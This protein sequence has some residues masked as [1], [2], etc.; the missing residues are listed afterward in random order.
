[1]A[2]TRTTALAA[3]LLAGGLIAGC[4]SASKTTPAGQSSGAS[5][6]ASPYSSSSGSSSTSGSSSQ[7][8]ALITTKKHGKL[9]TILA[10]GP[11]KLTVYLF[12]ADKGGKSSC[13][14]QC[15]KFWPPVIGTPKAGP[16]A[17]PADLG[18]ITRSDGTKQLAYNGHPLYT[19]ANDKDGGDS[20]GQGQHAFGADWYA[21]SPSGSKVDHS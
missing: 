21:L 1:M 11:K 3:S 2:L 14:G 17:M 9:G 18:T 12:E 8:V 19:F 10:Y 16:G 5:A 13:S 4:G 15:A 7:R 20:Y 6:S